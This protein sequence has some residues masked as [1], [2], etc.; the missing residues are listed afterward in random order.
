VST[1]IEI[2]QVSKRFRL[3]QEKYNS[4]KERLLHGGRVPHHDFWALRDIDVDVLEG[5]TVG[6]LGRNGCGKSTLLKCVAGILK[7][8][9]G[10]IRLRGSL[11]AMLEL[12]AGFQPELSGRDNIYLNASLLGMPTKEIDRR[13]DEI[14]AFAELEEFIDNEVRFYSSGM[15]VRLGFAVAVNADPHILL[16]D[17]VLAVGDERFQQ[18]CMQRIHEFQRDGRTIVVVSHAADLMRQLCNRVM[19][20]NA[21]QLVTVAPPGEAIR[22]FR[23][24]LIDAGDALGPLGAGDA[25]VDEAPHGNGASPEEVLDTSPFPPP[26]PGRRVQLTASRLETAT[27]RAHVLPGEP[28]TVVV[29]VEASERIE[30]VAFGCSVWGR[31][32]SLIF[33]FDSGAPVT[34]ERG[35]STLRFHFAAVP[36]LD[37]SYAVNVRVQD[38][39]GGAVHARLEPAAQLLVENPGTSTGL[40]SMPVTVE[41]AHEHQP[42]DVPA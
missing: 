11:A 34:L 16:V 8:T 31:N 13:F 35:R 23:E 3:Y 41:L 15:Y 38:P 17:E 42:G 33:D 4:L 18:K 25:L 29:E 32:G 26:H 37:G 24:V 5:E 40:V 22:A 10:E 12:G 30:G 19:V 14:V 39:G 21:G 36:L 27:G 28:A 2:R 9:S 1:A 6:I 7:P 20:I